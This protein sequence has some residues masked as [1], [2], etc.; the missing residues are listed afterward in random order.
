VGDA[1]AEGGAEVDEVADEHFVWFVRGKMCL[2]VCVF[3]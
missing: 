1:V 2:C 3:V